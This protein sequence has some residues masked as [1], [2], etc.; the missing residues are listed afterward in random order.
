MI[1]PSLYLLINF[2]VQLYFFRYYNGN[3]FLLLNPICVGYFFYHVFS[4]RW[5]LSLKLK[6]VCCR[7]QIDLFCFLKHFANLGLL[8]AVL[9]SLTL[10][11]SYYWKVW[12]LKL[13]CCS[14]LVCVLSYALYFLKLQLHLFSFQS[15]L[16]VLIPVFTSK[17]CFQYSV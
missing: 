17:N 5:Y 2:K 9:R 8:I 3:V 4:L 10:R 12:R 11:V 13:F 15:L 16:A 6:W 14:L 1:F 7:Q